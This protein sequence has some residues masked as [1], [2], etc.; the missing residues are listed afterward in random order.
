MGHKMYVYGDCIITENEWDK[1]LSPNTTLWKIGEGFG[2]SKEQ[3]VAIHE[4]IVNNVLLSSVGDFTSDIA[5]RVLMDI[6]LDA[7]LVEKKQQF[8]MFLMGAELLKYF[9]HKTVKNLFA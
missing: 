7:D 2:L 5:G 8:A 6:S 3:I 1:I 4:T 9:T